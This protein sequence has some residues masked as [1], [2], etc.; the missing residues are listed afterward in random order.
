MTFRLRVQRADNSP[1]RLIIK[2][3]LRVACYKTS[4][5]SFSVYYEDNVIRPFFFIFTVGFEKQM[6]T[7]CLFINC[8]DHSSLGNYVID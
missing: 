5:C 3:Q 1:P 7:K 2:Q 4:F 8:E 6:V